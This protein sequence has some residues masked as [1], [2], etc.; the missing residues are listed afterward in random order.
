MAGKLKFVRTSPN[1]ERWFRRG[2]AKK[3]STWDVFAEEELVAKIGRSDASHAYLLIPVHSA[4]G[5]K[6]RKVDWNINKVKGYFQRKW[7]KA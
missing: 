7:D 4:M 1:E 2:G 5:D 3:S 6:V